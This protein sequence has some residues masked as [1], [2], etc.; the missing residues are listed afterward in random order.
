MGLLVQSRNSL[1]HRGGF[2]CE[3]ADEDERKRCTPLPTVKD[4][5]CFLL[6]FLDKVFLKLLG[7]S[8]PY[9]NWRSPEAPVVEVLG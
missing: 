6:N 5:Y 9:I 3:L 1:I 2:Y 7:Y 8:G 4:E